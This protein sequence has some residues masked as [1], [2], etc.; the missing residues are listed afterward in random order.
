MKANKTYAIN[1]EIFKAIVVVL[2]FASAGCTEVGSDD[3][4]KLEI[5]SGSSD[6][7]DENEDDNSD[8]SGSSE[9]SYD[10]VEVE[11]CDALATENTKTFFANL[12]ESAKIGVIVGQQ[13]AYYENDSHKYQTN[14][15]I[16]DMTD[17]YPILTGFDIE[18]LTN[19][20]YN[21]SNWR[22]NRIVNYI[23]TIKECH[24]QGIFATI[25]WH[26]REPFYGA[27]FYTKD[28]D[29][30]TCAA[31][32]PSILEGGVNHTYFKEKL[33][34]LADFFKSLE[35][36]NGELIP[37]IFRPFHEFNG[38][39]FWWGVP[40]YATPA[41]F[42]Q[43]WQFMVDFLRNDCDVHNVIYAFTPGFESESDYLESYP[44]DDYIDILGYDNYTS[45][46]IGDASTRE[47]ELEQMVTELNIISTL[48]K[49][50]GKV[51]ALTETGHDIS[52]DSKV[53][54]NVYTD[55][56]LEA[57]NKAETNIA[58]VMFW[59]NSDKQFTP[60]DDDAAYIEDF[61]TF[62][63]SEKILTKDEITSPLFTWSE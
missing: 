14:C 30:E 15:D 54:N 48:A 9:E 58:Y 20:G 39:W 34:L 44:G 21:E 63:G 37:V 25:S 45:N 40:Y 29:D 2:L 53:V 59:Y 42:I 13:Q 52:D 26:F 41:Q 38:S 62:I 10:S 28:L 4:F 18:N 50:R 16:S 60:Y 47:D 8:N 51:A 11:L 1:S 27:S 24:K 36:E 43:N 31:A 57:L 56:F 32:F 33:T 5:G 61:K 3:G 49:K 17:L 22:Y 35:D 55:Y 23:E 7:S 46:K 12:S 6:N 19:D